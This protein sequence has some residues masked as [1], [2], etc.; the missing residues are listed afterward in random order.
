MTEIISERKILKFLED[1]PAREFTVKK[2]NE[3]I[4]VNEF[5]LQVKMKKLY[6][7]GQVTRTKKDS[8][9]A[10]NAFYYSTLK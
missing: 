7:R 1:N 2:I 6:R 10:S 4:N 3:I 5:S 9:Y 8:G